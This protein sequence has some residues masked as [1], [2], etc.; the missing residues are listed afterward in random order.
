MKFEIRRDDLSGP[1]IQAL[2]REHMAGML[3]NSPLESVHALPLESLRS[4]DITFWSVWRDDELCGCGALKELDRTHGEIKSMRTKPQFLRRGVGQAAL[5]HIIEEAKVRSY[6]RL[7]LETGTGEA[8]KPALAMYA[9][10]GFEL[11]DPFAEY[12]PDPFSVFM[13]KTF[14]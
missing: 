3:S 4:P 2:V 10:N 11:C 13:T 8:F 7:S 14:R 5:N 12:K 9:R 6:S 1:E